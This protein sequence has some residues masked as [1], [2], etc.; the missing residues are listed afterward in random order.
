HGYGR[1]RRLGVD[2]VQPQNPRRSERCR[3]Q[4]DRQ[5]WR[6]RRNDRNRQ[7]RKDRAPVQYLRH[8]SRLCRCQRQIRDRNLSVTVSRLPPF[9]VAI[10]CYN[11]AARIGETVRATL[12]Y[13]A[14]QS[15]DAEL[16]VVNDGSTDETARI[17]RNALA[18]AKIQTR[19]LENFP[20]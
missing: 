8:V 10:P 5:T 19:L 16:V 18:G 17:V 15:T 14:A 2:G 6:H 3:H 1:A 11:E 20:N 12:D 13:L 9:S 4:Q 7:E